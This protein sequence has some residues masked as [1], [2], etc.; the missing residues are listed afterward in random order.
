M[1]KIQ[2]KCKHEHLRLINSFEID[3]FDCGLEW[4][5][6]KLIDLFR[7]ED[8][9]EILFSFLEIPVFIEY[10]IVREI[11]FMIGVDHFPVVQKGSGIENVPSLID[12]ADNGSNGSGRL[13]NLLQGL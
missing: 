9:D 2:K 8:E 4:H 12:K 1:D 7:V 6:E 13:C 11:G 5:R 10:A 3:C